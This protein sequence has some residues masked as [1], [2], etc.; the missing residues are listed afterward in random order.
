M[1]QHLI[2]RAIKIARQCN[3]NITASSPEA[4]VPL[5]E[6]W[7]PCEPDTALARSAACHTLHRSTSWSPGLCVGSENKFYMYVCE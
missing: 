4:L 3:D 2:L 7:R 1:T 6:P 5:C